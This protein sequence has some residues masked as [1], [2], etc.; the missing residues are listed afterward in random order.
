[1]E[2]LGYIQQNKG[3]EVPNRKPYTSDVSEN[4]YWQITLY[5]FGTNDNQK[6]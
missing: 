4:I 1:M 3:F 5:K 2:W 6:N